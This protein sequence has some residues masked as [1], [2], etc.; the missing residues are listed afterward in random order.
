M[1]CLKLDVI[2]CIGRMCPFNDILQVKWTVP[3][4]IYVNNYIKSLF[5]FVVLY[6]K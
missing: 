5:A 4:R 3:N 6:F 2:M 1:Y